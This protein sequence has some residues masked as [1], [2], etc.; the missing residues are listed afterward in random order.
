MLSLRGAPALSEFRLKKLAQRISEIHPDIQ[1]LRAEFVHFVQLHRPLTEQRQKILASLL[2]YGPSLP[3]RGGSG[4]QTPP[5]CWLS[6]GR[7]LSLPGLA[8]PP[9]SPTTVAYRRLN[10]WSEVWLGISAYP[11]SSLQRHASA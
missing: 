4:W 6:L 1:I 8:K 11:Q 2:T 9:I 5:Y 10:G 7:A 3:A